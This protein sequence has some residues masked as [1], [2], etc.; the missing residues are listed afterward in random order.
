MLACMSCMCMLTKLIRQ[1]RLRV[2][3]HRSTF[4]YSANLNKLYTSLEMD[5]RHRLEK[6]DYETQ[7]FFKE[8]KSYRGKT[9]YWSEVAI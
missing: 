6:S 7:T 4:K 1:I 8:D 9:R 3:Q 5:Q 2:N